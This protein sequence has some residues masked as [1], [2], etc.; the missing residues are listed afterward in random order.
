MKT[1]CSLAI[2][3]VIA[4]AQTSFGLVISP[5]ERPE[6]EKWSVVTDLISLIGADRS[7]EIASCVTDSIDRHGILTGFDEKII[8]DALDKYAKCIE[9]GNM[10]LSF[11]FSI[12]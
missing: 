1:F 7:L 4:M 2:V 3:C 12:Y 6:F 10:G 8:N 11:V 5:N 9:P